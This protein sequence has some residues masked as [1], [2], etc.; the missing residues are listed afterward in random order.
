MPL[1]KQVPLTPGVSLPDFCADHV[2][3]SFVICVVFCGSRFILIRKKKCEG[4]RFSFRCCIYVF[5]C[6]TASEHPLWYLQTS[7]QVVKICIKHIQYKHYVLNGS[8]K[9]LKIPQGYSQA[10]NRC[11]V[12][13]TEVKKLT[14]LFQVR[15]LVTASEDSLLK[16]LRL[17]ID[18]IQL[19]LIE[20][21]ADISLSG[22]KMLVKD[23]FDQNKIFE[24]MSIP[25]MPENLAAN[26]SYSDMTVIFMVSITQTNLPQ[27]VPL[28]NRGPG[29]FNELGSWITQQL[30]QAYH[31]YGIG[32]PPA[33]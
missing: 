20:I 7:F 32:S 13:V 31:H 11:N 1:L 21:Y 28:Y 23:V 15:P 14:S 8:M 2:A 26:S 19:D 22:Y 10:V 12:C 24:V 30:I 3:Q 27:R 4:G 33:L 5:V 16:I 29:W 17:L 18:G 25:Q 6:V 9:S